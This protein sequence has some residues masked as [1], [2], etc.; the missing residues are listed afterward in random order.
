MDSKARLRR[1]AKMRWWS[2][3]AKRVPYHLLGA[4]SVLSF[5]VTVRY[6]DPVLLQSLRLQIFD[7]Y[8]RV[9]PRA[10]NGHHVA[11]VDIDERSLAAIGQWPW[12]RTVVSDLTARL[13]GMGAAVVAF[14]VIFAE[15]DRMSAPRPAEQMPGLTEEGRDQLRRLPGNDA[16]LAATI[17]SNK[18]VLAQAGTDLSSGKSPAP[19][20]RQAA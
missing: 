10:D 13:F 1:K 6:T 5:G 8:Q 2:G 7:F 11:I 9:H 4:V 14:D 20:R 17:R 16:V 19:R 3:L 12:P 18:V 15:P